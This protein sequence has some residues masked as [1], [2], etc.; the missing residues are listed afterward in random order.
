MIGALRLL[1]LTGCRKSEV[2][3]LRWD[4][5]DLETGYL[6]LPDA[7]TGARSVAL[8]EGAKTV[9]RQMADARTSEYVFPSQQHGKHLSDIGKVWRDIRSS[10]GLEDVTIHDLRRSFGSTAHAAGVDIYMIRE[11]LGHRDLR[12][13]QIYVR[14]ADKARQEAAQVAGEMISRS[15]DWEPGIIV[16]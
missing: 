13:T 11:L 3:M 12:T 7:K 5:V 9:L 14:V 10:A 1:L 6:H 4:D 2:L 16:S 15:M 8:N